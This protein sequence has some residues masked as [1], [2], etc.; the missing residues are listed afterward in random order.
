MADGCNR[1]PER[2]LAGSLVGGV[3]I[4]R[5]LGGPG[6]EFT[7]RSFTLLRTKAKLRYRNLMRGSPHLTHSLPYMH[8][9]PAGA[10]PGTGGTCLLMFLS[11]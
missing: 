3:W 8:D 6:I 10:L 1:H 11:C 9:S 7:W 5:G 4:K 2:A